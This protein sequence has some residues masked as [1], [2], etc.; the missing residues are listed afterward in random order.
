MSFLLLSI[1]SSTSIFLVFKLLDLKN[2]PIFNVILIN[3]IVAALIGFFFDNS[4]QGILA[5]IKTDAIWFSIII[6][7]LFIVMFFIIGWSSQRAGIAVT[8]VASKMSVVMPISFSLFFF[9]ES[10][11]LI[12]GIGILIALAAVFLTIYKK[13]DSKKANKMWLPVILFIGMGMVDISVKY[14]QE[15]YVTPETDSFFTAFLFLVSAI[16]A[17]IFTFF[18]TKSLKDYKKIPVWIYGVLLGATNFGT[19]YFLIATLNSKVFPSSVIFGVNNTSIVLLSFLLG[20]LFFK[21]RLLKI[22]IVGISLSIIAIFLLT[23]FNG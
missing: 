14:A 8:S 13:S 17:I 18:N 7:L 19:I 9:H 16:F 21:E 15:K 2:I 5:F 10:L 3:Y 6:G 1:A 23:F 4:S 20:L 11:T 12:K 22:N